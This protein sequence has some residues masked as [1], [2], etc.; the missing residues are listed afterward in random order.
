V[1]IAVSPLSRFSP[2][3]ALSCP[4]V[5]AAVN[6]IAGIMGNLPV[7]L[8]QQAGGGGKSPQIIRRSVSISPMQTRGR[9]LASFGRIL[10]LTRF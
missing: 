1:A 6:L 5:L 8:Y 2:L 3:N 9:R 4:P 7:A 10:P